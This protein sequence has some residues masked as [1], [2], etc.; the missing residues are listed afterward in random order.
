MNHDADDDLRRLFYR[1]VETVPTLSPDFTTSVISQ[2]RA[3]R[4]ARRH[5]L[6]AMAVGVVVIIGAAAW[7]GP[8]LVSN[9]TPEPGGRPHLSPSPPAATA[10]CLAATTLTPGVR[11]RTDN[12]FIQPNGRQVLNGGS[13]GVFVRKADLGER[14]PLSVRSGWLMCYDVD[15]KGAWIFVASNFDDTRA[16]RMDNYGH[17][18]LRNNTKYPLN[19]T[20]RASLS[21]NHAG[22]IDSIR[23]VHGAAGSPED[24]ML[25]L[26]HTF[27][28][29]T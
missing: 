24:V 5:R 2:G 26:A 19:A 21:F 29:C 10:K 12:C 17:P 23:A 11:A 3:R 14:W 8:Q 1:S 20:A 18:Y 13:S 16:A 27:G 22:E 9:N 7:Q 4:Q 6:A 15:G 25:D 28:S